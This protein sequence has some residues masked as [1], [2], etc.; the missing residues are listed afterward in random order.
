MPKKILLAEKSDAIRSIAESI[1]HQNGY[2]AI[3]A[4][5]IEK[6]KEL[7][8]TT[9]PNMVVLGAD[10]IDSEGKYLYDSLEENPMTASLP[11]L[12]IADPSGRSLPYPD[13]VILPR[14]FDPKDF[15]ERVRLFIGGGI[16]KQP[17]EKIETIDPFASASID[18]EFLDV[19]LGIDNIDVE[20]SEVMD[21][22]FMTGKLK[23]PEPTEKQAGFEIHQPEVDDSA[24][25]I[26][27]Q[28][29]ESLMIREEVKSAAVKKGDHSDS[30]VSS[31]IEIAP[32]QYGLINPGQS[33]G[34]ENKHSPHDYDWFI[35]EMQKEASSLI[36][37]PVKTEPLNLK[38]NSDSIEPISIP[39]PPQEFGQDKPETTEPVI[40][41]GGVDQFIEEFKKE[42]VNITASPAETTGISK[43]LHDK[44]LP[45]SETE[46]VID[47]S[48]IRHFSNYLAELLAER[49]AKEI[50]AKIDAEEIYRIAKDDILRLLAEKN[51]P[52][53]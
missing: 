51:T 22:S 50:V 36:E 44:S 6:A 2:D 40:K 4:S 38:P 29:V 37:T 42:I 18:D 31:Q 25:K 39:Q 5:S 32:D 8:I 14:P 10:L 9:Q 41:L 33:T 43:E 26:E 11:V 35:K 7:I 47:P 19:A 34:S 20:A 23:I 49:L 24:N 15:L 28:K 52:P 27:N 16:E 17:Q 53:R 45:F 3:S 21:K 13:E 1:L 12:L 46:P 48:E 30:S